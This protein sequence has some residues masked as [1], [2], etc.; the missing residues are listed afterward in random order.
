VL[1][2]VA[3]M[4]SCL[5]EKLIFL[6]EK[7]P[8]DYTFRFNRHFTEY[9]I[10]V[11]GKHRLNGLL[12]EADSSKGLVFYL[13]G[14]AGSNRSWGDICNVYLN[15]SYDFFVLDYRGYGK[16]DGKI[17]SEKQFHSDIQIAYDLLKQKY[18]EKNIVVIGF[19]IGTGPAAYLASQNRPKLLILNAPYYNIPDL[20]RKYFRI[21]PGFLI[22]YKFRTDKYIGN[23]LCPVTIFHGDNDEIIPASSSLKLK[24]LFKEHDS[25]IILKN[26][27]HNGIEWNK[28]YQRELKNLLR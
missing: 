11:D 2:V 15:N 12:F 1:S 5:Q 14:N 25:L 4:A 26:Q 20:A 22:R 18:R 21:F 13:H 10:P 7:L 28:D 8:S 24:Q 3:L 9:S 6:P 16:S 17:R 23:I 27:M 19:S